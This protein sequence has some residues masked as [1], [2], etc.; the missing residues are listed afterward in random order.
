[1]NDLLSLSDKESNI[2]LRADKAAKTVFGFTETTSS[3]GHEQV[4]DLT[5]AFNEEHAEERATAL[6]KMR[7]H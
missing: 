1:M 6:E 2:R 5:A 7:E 3:V 4:E